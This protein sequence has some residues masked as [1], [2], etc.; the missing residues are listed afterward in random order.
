[1]HAR[2]HCLIPLFASFGARNVAESGLDQHEGREA[3]GKGAHDACASPDCP[4]AQLK[5]VVGLN[6]PPMIAGQAQ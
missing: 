2:L 3:V 1:M 5:R 6:L 4:D